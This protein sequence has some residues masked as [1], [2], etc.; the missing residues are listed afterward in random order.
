MSA[1]WQTRA[2]MGAMAMAGAAL[3]GACSGPKPDAQANAMHRTSAGPYVAITRG[4]Y[5]ARAGDCEDCH[6]AKGGK[7]WAGGRA[8]PTPFG[9]IYSTNI[10]PDPSTGIGAWTYKDFYRAMHTGVARDGSKLYPAFPYPWFTRMSRRDVYDLKAYLDTLTPVHERNHPNALPWPLSMR[11]VMGIWNKMYFTAGAFR[12]DPDKSAQWNRGAYLVRSVG[13]CGACHSSKNFAGA[14]DMDHPY[15]GGKAEHV[16]AP[17]LTA[18][19][20][21]GLGAWSVD[22]IAEYLGTGSNAITAAAG[23]MATVVRMSTQYLTD[24][25]RHDIAVYLKSVGA[26]HPQRDAHQKS[27]HVDDSVMAAGKAVYVDDCTGCHMDD[28]KGLQHAFPPLRNSSAILAAQPQTLIEAVLKGARKP[29]TKAKP[30]GLQMPAFDRKL[31]D[32]QVANVLT[33]IRNSWGNHASAVSSG[34]VGKLR[35]TLDSGP[36]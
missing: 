6:T 34:A 15:R 7:P 31:T 25:D 29:P 20:R 22:D 35:H 3:L 11:S 18:D 10:T 33:Y 8:V 27:K 32:A 19:K 14:S 4:R 16:F 26:A 28:G 36:P 9:I 12:P 23:P 30:T 24:A 1:A 5:L 2:L 21:T 17:D 13:H